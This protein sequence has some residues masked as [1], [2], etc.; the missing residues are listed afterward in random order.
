MFVIYNA[1][2][3]LVKNKCEKRKN[4]TLLRNCVHFSGYVRSVKS[5]H[6]RNFSFRT[7]NFDFPRGNLN[8]RTGN[9]YRQISL[10][11]NR[12]RLLN[13]VICLITLT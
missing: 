4:N 12:L 8:F 5:F 6:R 2:R 11:Y 1:D 13:T 7:G 3:Y 9:F 10:K